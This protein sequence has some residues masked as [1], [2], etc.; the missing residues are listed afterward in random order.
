[1]RRAIF[2]AAALSLV[3]ASLFVLLFLKTNGS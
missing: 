1:M 3:A 2:F